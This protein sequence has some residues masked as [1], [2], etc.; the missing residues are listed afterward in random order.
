MLDYLLLFRNTCKKGLSLWGWFRISQAGCH[1]GG[2]HEQVGL[3]QGHGLGETRLRRDA[4]KWGL[5]RCRGAGSPPS[6]SQVVFVWL[7]Q[8]FLHSSDVT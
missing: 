4:Q 5:V 3:V 1:D 8:P 7:K 2:R 6:A